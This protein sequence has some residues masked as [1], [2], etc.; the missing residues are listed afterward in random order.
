MI[1]FC[2]L[3]CLLCPP[4]LAA[5][6]HPGA[7]GA[8]QATA[9]PSARDG[10]SARIPLKGDEPSSAPAARLSTGGK[11]RDDTR[12]GFA[13]LREAVR[14]V[15]DKALAPPSPEE[16]ESLAAKGYMSA[17][18][19]YSTYI[20]PRESKLLKERSDPAFT[21]VGMDLVQDDAGV[22]YCIPYAGSP[23]EKAGI[24]HGDVLRFVDGEAAEPLPLPVLQGRIRGRE[25]EPVRL[26]VLGGQGPREVS[27]VRAPIHVPS[28][29]LLRG[30]AFFRI[31]LVRFDA[32]TRGQLEECLAAV[33]PGADIVLDL[34]GNVGG[35]LNVA[36]ACAERFLPENAL[37]VSV[38]YRDGEPG[39]RRA[40]AGEKAG[41]G[42]LAL[43]QDRFTASAAEVF[44][45]A[46]SRNGRGKTVGQRSFGKGVMQQALPAESGG[47]FI[48]TVAELLPPDGK[49]YHAR[50]LEP[51]LLVARRS[52][53][54]QE[55]FIR[56]TY[57]AFGKRP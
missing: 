53:S 25:G 48:L 51:D 8:A 37:M 31:R 34:R 24:A 45:A 42:R 10:P 4:V 1:R 39:E 41:V 15:G 9:R 18:D 14:L 2:L 22:L 12:G 50:G 13:A 49:A 23:A 11:T 33:P 3:L 38:A 32:H 19:A 30:E 57:E 44:C 47:I 54:I 55:D 28:A 6:L 17:V 20:S 29:E 35:D 36:L 40:A 26:G 5:A 21:G 7:A 43:W 46:L 16:A 27:V 56:R 52:A